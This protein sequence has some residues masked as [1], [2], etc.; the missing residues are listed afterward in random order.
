[1]TLRRWNSFNGNHVDV[2]TDEEYWVSGPRRD[3]NAPVHIDDDAR[4]EYDALVAGTQ[5]QH[6]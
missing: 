3:S 2:D 4:A 5:P 1:M 6:R